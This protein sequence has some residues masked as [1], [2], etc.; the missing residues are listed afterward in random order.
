MGDESTM[1]ISLSHFS[2]HFG[3]FNKELMGDL[4]AYETGF[5]SKYRIQKEHLCRLT[6]SSTF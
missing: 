2:V 3:G 5:V 1:F 4:L 6:A